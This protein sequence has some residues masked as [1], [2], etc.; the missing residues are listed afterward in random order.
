MVSDDS[1]LDHGIFRMWDV[2]A[3]NSI[4]A[5]SQKKHLSVAQQQ[6]LRAACRLEIAIPELDMQ[7]AGAFN[8]MALHILD[9]PPRTA[10]LDAQQ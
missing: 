2:L 7:G 6:L 3:G 9:N 1:L 8:D 4:A 10:R 5:S